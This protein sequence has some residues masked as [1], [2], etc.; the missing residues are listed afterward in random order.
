MNPVA[1]VIWTP[2]E[3]ETD[4]LDEGALVD[5]VVVGATQVGEAWLGPTWDPEV[6]GAADVVGTAAQ[7]PVAILA[8]SLA[9][10]LYS[11]QRSKHW[12]IKF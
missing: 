12:W 8:C 7:M 3:E 5:P 6:T 1:G 2:N 4:G 11:G 9:S 10:I